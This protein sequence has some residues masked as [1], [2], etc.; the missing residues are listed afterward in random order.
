MQ[1]L[2]KFNESE[3]T[4]NPTLRD[5]IGDVKETKKIGYRSIYRDD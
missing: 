1:H 4:T 2:K 3:E 5:L